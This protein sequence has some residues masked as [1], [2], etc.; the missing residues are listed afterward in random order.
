MNLIE[1]EIWF[2]R[3]TCRL[4]LHLSDQPIR[5]SSSSS[6]AFKSQKPL[7][8]SSTSSLDSQP[9]WTFLLIG[10]IFRVLLLSPV[11]VHA[12]NDKIA[13]WRK[14]TASFFPNAVS[15]LPAEEN[16]ICS[17]IQINKKLIFGSAES[18]SL[19]RKVV[20]SIDLFSLGPSWPLTRHCR[21]SDLYWHWKV[22]WQSYQKGKVT[23]SIKRGN[24]MKFIGL[25]SPRSINSVRVCL[26]RLRGCNNSWASFWSEGQG[27]KK[28]K[29][30]S[31]SATTTTATEG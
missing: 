24:K 18:E 17:W 29:V 28:N 22:S 12:K 9:R 2:T 27:K 1:E 26:Q 21:W 13:L 14:I 15:F 11:L 10:F 25:N 31:L 16:Q 5:S 23:K 20:S 4:P 3:L 30:L 6:S 8:S 19:S 7:I